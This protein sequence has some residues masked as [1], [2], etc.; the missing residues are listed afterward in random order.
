MSLS[1]LG[2]ADPFETAF[3][4]LPLSDEL[5]PAR[6]AASQREHYRLLAAATSTR[7]G[8]SARSR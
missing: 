4:E 2:W 8:S 1:S 7:G 3:A 6:V 5:Q